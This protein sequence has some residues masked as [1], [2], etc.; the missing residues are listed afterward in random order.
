MTIP[1]VGVG[2]GKGSK[3]PNRTRGGGAWLWS[4]S[5]LTMLQQTFRGHG[6]SLAQSFDVDPL[7]CFVPGF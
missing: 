7:G 4:L 3:G 2:E 6:F 5:R 1:N